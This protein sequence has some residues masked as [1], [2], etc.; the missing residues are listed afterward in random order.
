MDTLYII[1]ATTEYFK[2]DVRATLYDILGPESIDRLLS[3]GAEGLYVF[4]VAFW[5][6]PSVNLFHGTFDNPTNYLLGKELPWTIER[7]DEYMIFK[8][9]NYPAPHF[10]RN[11]KN[12]TNA[13]LEQ[14]GIG[15][16]GEFV[17]INLPSDENRDTYWE[18]YRDGTYYMPDM[19]YYNKPRMEPLSAMDRPSTPVAVHEDF[20]ELRELEG[21]P[22]NQFQRWR[23]FYI[24]HPKTWPKDLTEEEREKL[25]KLY[26]KEYKYKSPWTPEC[27]RD[28]TNMAEEQERRELL[29]TPQPREIYEQPDYALEFHAP[30]LTR[31]I[32][33]NISTRELN[34]SL[35]TP[36]P[37][38]TR[39]YWEDNRLLYTNDKIVYRS[40]D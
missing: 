4:I 29:E 35:L 23:D 8:D 7:L 22:A 16:P 15:G 30:P 21:S 10:L 5:R 1:K 28:P 38:Q 39:G 3:I 11:S 26:N 32:T 12:L 19:T 33:D 2:H 34:S 18:M 13:E 20:I 6:V 14:L 9:G 37:S 27:G 17:Y 25:E 40:F 31:S 24:E 36:F